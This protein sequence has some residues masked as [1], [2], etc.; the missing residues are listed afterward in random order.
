MMDEDGRDD[1]D[2]PRESACAINGLEAHYA[3]NRTFECMYAHLSRIA[4][5]CCMDECRLS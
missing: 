1:R 5:D 4:C 2:S 3:T